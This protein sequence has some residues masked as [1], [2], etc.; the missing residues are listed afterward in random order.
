MQL[1]PEQLAQLIQANDAA[2]FEDLT[3]FGNER[4]RKILDSFRE[5]VDPLALE[6]TAIEDR[7]GIELNVSAAGLPKFKDASDLS[8][9]HNVTPLLP[10]LLATKDRPL[11][12]D[13]PRVKFG[14]TII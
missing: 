5:T 9:R 4:S 1:R 8:R 11:I 3:A 10:L 12:I 2:S 6:V 7:I 13:K 14:H